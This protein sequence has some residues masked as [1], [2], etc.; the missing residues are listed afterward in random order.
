M[1]F[2]VHKIDGDNGSFLETFLLLGTFFFFFSPD[3]PA[4]LWALST[5]AWF[6]PG[7]CVLRLQV[8]AGGLPDTPSCLF[9]VKSPPDSTKA[10]FP[11]HPPHHAGPIGQQGQQ[12][13]STAGMGLGCFLFGFSGELCHFVFHVSFLCFTGRETTPFFLPWQTS[14]RFWDFFCSFYGEREKMRWHIHRLLIPFFR[15]CK[16]LSMYFFHVCVRLRTSRLVLRIGRWGL[17]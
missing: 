13:L 12:R 9:A 14:N 6:V 8:C 3:P 16:N 7:F 15:L 1:D 2:G 10:A 5:L 4:A 17:M 11:G